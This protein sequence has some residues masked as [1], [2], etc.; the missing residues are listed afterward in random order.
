ME[1]R[2]GAAKGSRVSGPA[3]VQVPGTLGAHLQG[4]KGNIRH[5][6]GYIASIV[7]FEVLYAIRAQ[8]LGRL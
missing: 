1:G 2:H 4:M 5:I 3:Q 6:L 7:G 8:G